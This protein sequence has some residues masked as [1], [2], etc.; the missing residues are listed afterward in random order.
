VARSAPRSRGM[1][2]GLDRLREMA[3]A[4]G[5]SRRYRIRLTVSSP[6]RRQA[7]RWTAGPVSE[8]LLYPIFLD[9]TGVPV[10]VLGGGAVAERKTRRLLTAGARI[11]LISPEVTPW[12]AEQARSGRLEWVRTRFA[13]AAPVTAR[14]VFAATSDPEVNRAAAAAARRA[15]AWV[16]VADPPEAGD[17][18]VPAELRARTYQIAIT[19]RHGVAAFARFLRQHWEGR[20]D[21]WLDDLAELLAELRHDLR[22]QV[23]S[24]PARAAALR[25]VVESPV[26]EL[27]QAGRRDE[28]RQRARRLAGIEES[29]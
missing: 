15:G 21:P 9:L 25:R 10:L 7:Q 16:N 22:K 26:P 2:P 19:T 14:L 11:R 27:L 12:L 6:C 4:S 18:Q 20:L 5:A 23:A 29:T 28:A 8:A 1:S 17:F 24:A 3:I 13:P